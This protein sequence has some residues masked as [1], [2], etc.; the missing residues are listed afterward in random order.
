MAKH[1]DIGKWGESTARE[2][3][4]ARG[5]A[6]MSANERIGAIEIDI[7]ATKGD[8]L[9]FIEVKTRSSSNYDPLD[10]IDSKKIHRL[11]RAADSYIRTKDLKLD[12]Q[13]DIITVIGDPISGLT[14][15]EHFQDAAMPP[16]SGA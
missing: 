13:I 8:R 1:N 5:Y 14:K 12:P 11:C 16:L 2:Y 15:L 3:L 7:I 9:I 4:M 10:A 6:I